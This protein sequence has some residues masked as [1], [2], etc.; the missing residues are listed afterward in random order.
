MPPNYKVDPFGDVD[1]VEAFAERNAGAEALFVPVLVENKNFTVL[2]E[3]TGW[4]LED[5]LLLF[6][7]AVEDVVFDIA[8]PVEGDLGG[9][10]VLRDNDGL[11]DNFV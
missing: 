4:L 10:V 3:F 8:K 1:R 6:K 11:D 5:D 2:C 9:G 7:D